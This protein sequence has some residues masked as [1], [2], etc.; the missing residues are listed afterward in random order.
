M[1]IKQCYNSLVC[2]T[3]SQRVFT[4]S[5]E[6]PGPECGAWWRWGTPPDLKD[7]VV[8]LLKLLRCFKSLQI[9]LTLLVCGEGA[10]VA[11]FLQLLPQLHD[12]ATFNEALTAKTLAQRET[13]RLQQQQSDRKRENT[14]AKGA[15]NV[16]EQRRLYRGVLRCCWFE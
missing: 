8:S 6:G 7:R 2:E 5:A 14:P 13:R 10:A 3:D 11:E 9:R 12:V 1:S 15:D 16:A 4:V